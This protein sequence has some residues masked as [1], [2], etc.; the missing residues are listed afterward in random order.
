MGAG[1]PRRE[2]HHRLT[3]RGRR[4]TVV[5]AGL[6]TALEEEARVELD[7]PTI[8][9]LIAAWFSGLSEKPISTSASETPR[10]NSPVQKAT[11]PGSPARPS[12]F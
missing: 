3:C 11:P 2:H 1:D 4:G 9:G 12:T 6:R 5:P 10:C 8:C 7:P